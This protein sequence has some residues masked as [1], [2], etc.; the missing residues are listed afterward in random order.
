MWT[1]IKFFLLNSLSLLAAYP[2]K[3]EAKENLTGSDPAVQF[4]I[5]WHD[6]LN[7][8]MT[9]FHWIAGWIQNVAV[10]AA[11]DVTSTF[12]EVFKAMFS[13]LGWDGTLSSSGSPLHTLYLIMQTIGW[14][15]LGL[16]VIVLVL[17]SISHSVKWGKVLPNVVLVGLTLSVLPILM[18]TTGNSFGAISQNAVSEVSSA[19][20]NSKSS[21]M[22]E[23]LAVQPFKNN[24]FDVADEIRRGWKDNPDNVN[25]AKVNHVNK[26]RD[27]KNLDMSQVFDY[28]GKTAKA[29]GLEDKKLWG[30]SDSKKALDV[31]KYHLIDESG[32]GSTGAG[33]SIEKNDYLGFGTANDY[34]YSRY[35]VNWI[36]LLGQ[37]LILAFVLAAA[38]VRVVKDVVELTG[39]NLIAPVLA[40]QSVRSSKKL[41]DLINSIMGLYLSFVLIMIMIKVFFIFVQVAPTMSAIT[42][43]H[44]IPRSLATVAIYLGGAYGLFAGVSYY[45]RVTGV[46]QGFSQEGGQAFAGAMMGAGLAGAVVNHGGSIMRG[47]GNFI[48]SRSSHTGSNNNLSHASDALHSNNKNHSNGL[49]D[50]LGK[51]QQNNEANSQS[52]DKLTQNKT[53]DPNLNDPNSI[54]DD[55]SNDKSNNLNDPNNPNGQPVNPDQDSHGI[56]EFM[57]NN[58]SEMDANSDDPMNSTGG[59]DPDNNSTLDDPVNQQLD[60]MDNSDNVDRLPME[61]QSGDNPVDKEMGQNQGTNNST[62][63]KYDSNYSAG[64]NVNKE[65]D[66]SM[67]SEGLYS[68]GQGIANVGN[69]LHQAGSTVEHGSSQY[70]KSHRFNMSQN[71]HAHGTDSDRFDDE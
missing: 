65:S 13:L 14:A 8:E 10:H 57:D 11:Y 33:Y 70:L 52:Q 45:E 50:Y 12:E 53:N 39:M 48:N 32:A 20:T 68:T 27:V 47:A 69:K 59:I 18:R 35:K 64:G 51:E 54:K 4:Y 30:S 16:A 5:K 60:Q 3:I 22:T 55:T 26:G 67:P 17:Q 2:D 58:N 9:I 19:K 42:K 71:G 41:R 49:S 24:V 15:L 31:T 43:M 34:S 63:N 38:S 7:G 37:S 21:S 25:F 6:Y 36:G 56:N 44:S 28:K 29:L 62:L 1:A 46:S 40:Y 66:N 23:A 61:D